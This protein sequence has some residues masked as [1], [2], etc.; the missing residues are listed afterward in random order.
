MKNKKAIVI[1][2]AIFISVMF[3]FVACKKKGVD[4]AAYVTDENGVQLTDVN[5]EP[6][7]IIPETSVVTITD[8]NGNVVTNADGEAETSIYYKPQQVVVPVTNANH[9]AVTGPNG[10]ILTTQIWFPSN[11]TTTSIETV[12]VTDE[13]GNPVTNPDGNPVT[14]TTIISSA[15]KSFSKTMGGTT[16][17]DEAIAVAPASDGGIF[18]AVSGSSK[19]GLF[20]SI[21][22]TKDIGFAICKFDAEGTLVWSKAFG[23]GSSVSA[24]DICAS[25]DG[26]VIVAGQTRAKDFVSVNGSEYD[27]FIMKFDKDGNEVLRKSWGGTSNENFFSVAEGS[28]GSIYAAGFAYSQDGDVKSLAVP[29][30]D[31]RAVIVKF[32]ANGDVSKAVGVGGFGDYF[33]DIAVAKNGDVFAVASLN[34]G[35]TQTAYEK[36][37]GADA[38]VFKFNSDLALQFGK[39]FGGSG[40]ERFESI[41]VTDDGGFVIVGASTSSDGD[42]GAA[43]IKNRGGE[44]AVIAKFSGS[45]SVLF[46][47]SFYGNKNESFK[48]VAITPQGYIVAAG[49]SE[50]AVRDFKSIGNKGGKDAFVICYDS[51]GNLQNAGKG[52][53]GSGND[54][55]L[56]VCVMSNGQV[57][58]AGRSASTDE[59]LKDKIPASDTKNSVAFITTVLF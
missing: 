26:G 11:P 19:D 55:A 31:S 21:A 34:A 9:E 35:S 8:G 51:N 57:I 43:G 52:F 56:A 10:E 48:D 49:E 40:R 18:A 33:T 15:N 45:G 32:D 7:T 14:E 59:D 37:G 46:V 50:S 38:G 42:I 16:G 3:V 13:G 41:T 17:S 24:Q 54:V 22:D 27:A 47:K 1:I 28:D 44:D 30:G 4:G 39:S 58:I 29:Y 53:G 12:T 36:K 5:G 6:I 25:R 2:T 20:A 23:A